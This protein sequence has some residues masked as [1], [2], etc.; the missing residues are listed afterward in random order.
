[1]FVSFKDNAEVFF[2]LFKLLASK[3]KF[4]FNDIT[5]NLTNTHFRIVIEC[6]S[7]HENH[8][9]VCESKKP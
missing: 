8:G 7:F 3:C 1:M 6:Q 9:E 4:K 5:S 2:I